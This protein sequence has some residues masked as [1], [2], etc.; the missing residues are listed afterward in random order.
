MYEE[1]KGSDSTLDR[2]KTTS[3]DGKILRT[4][5][6]VGWKQGI[7]MHPQFGDEQGSKTGQDVWK[8]AARASI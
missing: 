4:R 1:W 8:G 5:H 2:S 7:C 6:F 3:V